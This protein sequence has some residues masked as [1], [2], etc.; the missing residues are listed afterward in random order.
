MK[1]LRWRKFPKPPRSASLLIVKRRRRNSLVALTVLVTILIGIGLLVALRIHLNGQRSGSTAVL[2]SGEG[3]DLPDSRFTPGAADPAVNQD[4]LAETICKKGYTRTVRPA[5]RYTSNLKRDQL[6][7]P[8]RGYSDQNLRDYE[9][10]HLIPLEIGGSPNDPRNL[11]PEH[12]AD[13][14]GARTKDRLEN[15]LHRR[16]CSQRDDADWVSLADAQ[17]AFSTNWI[18]SYRIYVAN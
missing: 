17:R 13:P 15:E 4:N 7:D 1:R 8:D 6:D 5:E 18:A 3:Y 14:E 2:S 12:W 9:E 11:G 10:D 16:I